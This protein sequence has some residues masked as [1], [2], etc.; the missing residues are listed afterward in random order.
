MEKSRTGTFSIYLMITFLLISTF[1]TMVI[2]EAHVIDTRS[3]LCP[4]GS[5][6]STTGECKTV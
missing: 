1:I 2:T 5:R 4:E 6:R 3:R